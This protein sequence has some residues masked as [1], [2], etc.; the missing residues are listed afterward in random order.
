MKSEFKSG[1]LLRFLFSVFL[2]MSLQAVDVFIKGHRGPA[3]R[4]AGPRLRGICPL[5]P[6]CLTL[7]PLCVRLQLCSSRHT[8]GPANHSVLG[9]T[10]CTTANGTL[11]KPISW[12]VTFEH[13]SCLHC[14][15]CMFLFVLIVCVSDGLHVFMFDKLILL[16]SSVWGFHAWWSLK[17]VS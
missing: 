10:L 11:H 4:I 2:S 3:K 12:P 14:I 7:R 17:S 16:G 13:T 6:P 9:Y 5:S 15:N 1:V 8:E